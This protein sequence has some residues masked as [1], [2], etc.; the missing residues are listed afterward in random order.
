VIGGCFVVA[1]PSTSA[2]FFFR[3]R[4]VYGNSKI[5][6]AIFGFLLFALFGLSFLVPIAIRGET[7][8]PTKRCIDPQVHVYA[9]AP[10][11]LN[12]VIDTLVF[13]AISCRI[14]CTS[15]VGN[16]FGARV[17]SFFLGDGLFNLSK[18]LLQGGQL[19]YLFVGHY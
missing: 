8:G 12:A 6:T 16:T 2:L 19:Y 17:R 18:S 3:V 14:V 1:V 9:S 13:V 15:L 10:V 4:G 7:I 11:V 5:I